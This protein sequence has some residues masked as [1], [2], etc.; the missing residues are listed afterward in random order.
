MKKTSAWL[1]VTDI[2]LSCFI[3]MLAF[4]AAFRDMSIN[5]MGPGGQG[6]LVLSV[7]LC[8]SAAWCVVYGFYHDR[9]KRYNAL[10]RHVLACVAGGSM[11]LPWTEWFDAVR[12]GVAVACGQLLAEV[13][14]SK[15]RAMHKND[16]TA[17]SAMIIA[18]FIGASAFWILP[19]LYTGESLYT[20]AW[21]QAMVLALVAAIAGITI[22]TRGS[23]VA[24]IAGITIATRGSLVAK[25]TAPGT[26]AQPV[27]DANPKPSKV[28]GLNST[29]FAVA[30]CLTVLA[31]PVIAC[32][33]LA[34]LDEVTHNFAGDTIPRGLLALNGVIAAFLVIGALV[35]KAPAGQPRE[36]NIN[37]KRAL[38]FWAIVAIGALWFV[39]FFFHE[40]D[41]NNR[42]T[43]FMMVAT[44]HV[45]LLY[46]L[47]PV[48]GWLLRT[49]VN[50][51]FTP[52]L[53]AGVA[54]CAAGGLLIGCTGIA[55]SYKGIGDYILNPV[56]MAVIA[57]GILG[58]LA[59]DASS[60]SVA[61]T[62]ST[63]VTRPPRFPGHLAIFTMA[64]A[65]GFTWYQMSM[66]FKDNVELAE[67]RYFLLYP[68]GF[69]AM[70]MLGLVAT[71][72]RRPL[73]MLAVAVACVSLFVMTC[74]L[75]DYEYIIGLVG[76]QCN[77]WHVV[78]IF[79]IPVIAGGLF[80][81]VSRYE[82]SKKNWG[83]VL[84]V[85]LFGLVTGYAGYQVMRWQ[86][87]VILQV[88]ALGIVIAGFA[89]C[90][91]R[92][93]EPPVSKGAA[94]LIT[95]IGGANDVR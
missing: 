79:T 18:T 74:F 5:V 55:Y 17:F 49:L 10:L 36:V 86:E 39:P 4:L 71:R 14:I 20:R 62:R 89:G 59:V 34:V 76:Q 13:V 52:K 37:R 65:I 66:Y 31:L 46:V 83:G 81:E 8:A 9:L 23:L 64:A 78:A 2:L 94:K 7:A 91:L 84:A 50:I 54:G 33:Y 69:I 88:V 11:L 16:A 95:T 47:P 73:V 26:A 53:L 77:M 60:T 42:E 38:A 45:A 72:S 85:A 27:D 58:T 21:F 51:P 32:I 12:I 24:A 6:L 90:F 28:T 41:F 1:D 15:S 35:V 93:H 80:P 75:P 30:A 48:A 82:I 29:G 68:L 87:H 40:I 63:E 57:L 22:A 67:M 19:G 61:P 56:S 44:I 70:A 3:A 92:S 25:A 43:P